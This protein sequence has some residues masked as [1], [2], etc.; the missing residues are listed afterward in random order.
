LY[1]T[2]IVVFLTPLSIRVSLFRCKVQNWNDTA[3]EPP[4][5]SRCQI[6]DMKQVPYWVSTNVRHCCTKFWSHND[7]V[8]WVCALPAIGVLPLKKTLVLW[9]KSAR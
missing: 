8:C 1:T 6:G 9:G 5:N 4:Q 3:K 7:L 2:I